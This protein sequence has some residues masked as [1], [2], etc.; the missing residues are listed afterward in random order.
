MAA[1]RCPLCG[2]PATLRPG[3]GR[4][5]RGSQHLDCDQRHAITAPFDTW[6]AAYAAQLQ[7]EVEAWL[8]PD[9]H[10]IEHDHDWG[11][12]EAYPGFVVLEC[13]DCEAWS[14]AP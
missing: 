13:R 12:L 3:P 2:E 1:Y 4:I 6:L 11:R 10:C 7:A 14:A 9:D 5:G 8:H